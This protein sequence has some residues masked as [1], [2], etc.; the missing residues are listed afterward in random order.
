MPEQGGDAEAYDLAQGPSLL[1]LKRCRAP[2][3]VGCS[4]KEGIVPGTEL[5][6]AP[7]GSSGKGDC[8]GSLARLLI[9]TDASPDEL[10]G[11]LC[12][13]DDLSEVFQVE[14]LHVFPRAARITIGT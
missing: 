8:Q 13:R 7:L 5:A 1:R 2:G 12:N 3:E 6:N 14:R 9:L 4:A 11:L 10:V